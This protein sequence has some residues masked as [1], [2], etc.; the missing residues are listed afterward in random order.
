[1]LL[2]G[3]IALVWI[4]LGLATVAAGSYFQ[5]EIYQCRCPKSYEHPDGECYNHYLYCYRRGWALTSVVFPAVVW[6]YAMMTSVARLAHAAGTQ[7]RAA[8]QA[9]QRD[10]AEVDRLLNSKP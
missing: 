9:R 4:A 1:M 5:W 7:R 10:M 3:V 6:V 8:Q 2:A